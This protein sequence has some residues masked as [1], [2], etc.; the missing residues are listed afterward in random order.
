[1]L[2]AMAPVRLAYQ[3]ALLYG[4]YWLGSFL[5]TTLRLPLPA[6]L[7]GLLLLLGLLWSGLVKPSHLSIVSGLVSRHLSFFFV[8]LAVGLM[9]WGDLLARSGL[10]L[11]VA[12]LASAAV[13]IGAAGVLAQTARRLATA[14]ARQT[15]PPPN[16]RPFPTWSFAEATRF[17]VQE[18]PLRRAA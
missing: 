15:V 18:A 11:G 7:L 4:V 17:D 16:L 8:P 12:L 14:R 13:G 1:M 2:I 5:V 6:N 3:C 10:V 9:A